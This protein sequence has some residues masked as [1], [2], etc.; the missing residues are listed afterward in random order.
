MIKEVSLVQHVSNRHNKYKTE[1]H[2]QQ[3]VLR[4]PSKGAEQ[5]EQWKTIRFKLNHRFY[6]INFIINIIIFIYCHFF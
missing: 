4:D 1:T 5:V 2:F 6:C 3:I